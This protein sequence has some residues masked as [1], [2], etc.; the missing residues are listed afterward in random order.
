MGWVIDH[1]KKKLSNKQGDVIL[2]S[3]SRL[4]TMIYDHCGDPKDVSNIVI[5]N[6]DIHDKWN[7][8][9]DNTQSLSLKLEEGEAI[10]EK[11]LKNFKRRG[12]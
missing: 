3:W 5:L 11:I 7:A 4:F 2:D 9:E 1:L 12:E 6:K 10:S 8:P